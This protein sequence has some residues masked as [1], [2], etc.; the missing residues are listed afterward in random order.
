MISADI[1]QK[2]VD[3]PSSPTLF[4]HY[5]REIDLKFQ[6]YLEIPKILMKIK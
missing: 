1:R 6:G 4:S 5:E 3:I 2:Y